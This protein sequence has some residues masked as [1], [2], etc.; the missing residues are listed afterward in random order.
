MY[1]ANGSFMKLRLLLFR[2]VFPFAYKNTHPH[3]FPA[4]LPGG[5]SHVRFDP[6]ERKS[7]LDRRRYARSLK[8]DK[9]GKIKIENVENPSS[10]PQPFD[11]AV[12]LRLL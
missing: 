1:G 6:L 12:N 10:E 7:I 2:R 9:N 8:R 5:I 3:A 4:R 11:T